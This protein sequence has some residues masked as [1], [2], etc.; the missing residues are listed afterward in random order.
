MIVEVSKDRAKELIEKVAVFFAE[1]RM[2]APALLFLES[3]RPLSFIGS[4][5]M[6]FLAPFANVLFQGQEFEE[7]AAVLSDRDNVQ[8]LIQRI[9]ELDEKLNEE[10]RKSEKLK[11]QKFW[12]KITQSAFFV[13]LKKI[14]KKN[15]D[16]GGK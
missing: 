13:K 2:G 8:I 9:D 11:R 6:Y 14:F 1:R 5:I 3:M 15:N 7:F 16:N 10:R 4:Q 12:K